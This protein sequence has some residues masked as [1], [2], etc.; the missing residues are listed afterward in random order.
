VRLLPCRCAGAAEDRGYPFVALHGR[1]AVPQL[2]RMTR[3]DLAST[4]SQRRRARKRTRTADSIDQ[5]LHRPARPTPRWNV[6]R[7]AAIA[8][9]AASAVPPDEHAWSARIAP[10]VLN[11]QRARHQRRS[12]AVEAPTRS[13]SAQPA[14]KQIAQHAEHAPQL[15]G[16]K[17]APRTR[18]K[19]Q[20]ASPW[21]APTRWHA[22]VGVHSAPIAART[23]SSPVHHARDVDAW[24]AVASANRSR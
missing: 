2:R 13:T 21:L 12:H 8:S 1:S 9:C 3:R 10:G 16:S 14:P 6:F 15:R 20:T 5:P 11:S 4:A 19:Q 24:L 17:A 23:V 18:P 7:A 22:R